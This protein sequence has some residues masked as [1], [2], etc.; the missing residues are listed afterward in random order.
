M[1][2]LLAWLALAVAR[3]APG[4]ALDTISR[5]LYEEGLRLEEQHEYQKAAVRFRAVW[6]RDPSF[7]HALVDL[8]RVLDSD[9]DASGAVAAYGLAPWDADAVEARGRLLLRGGGAEEALGEFR[10]LRTLRPGWSAGLLLEAEAALAFDARLAATILLDYLG[11]PDVPIQAEGAVALGARIAMSL[12]AGGW[13]EE[14]TAVVEALLESGPDDE[15]RARLAALIHRRDVEAI[16]DV[17]SRSAD[18]PLQP[19]QVEA[20]EAAREALAEGEIER[21]S[22]LVEEVRLRTP[23]SAETW[24]VRASVDEARGDWSEAERSLAIAEALE[25]LSAVWPAR[26]GRLLHERFAGRYDAE[27]LAAVERALEYAAADEELWV[28]RAE[29]LLALGQ[30]QGAAASASVYLELAPA[31]R[32]AVLAQELIADATRER[33]VLPDLPRSPGRP[34][35]IDAGAWRAYQLARAYRRFGEDTDIDAALAELAS[36]RQLQPRWSDALNLEA[37]IRVRRQEI[38]RAI[39]LYEQSL[40]VTPDQVG[41]MEVLA[42][43]YG[44]VG[45]ASEAEDLLEH[46]AEEGSAASL[47]A[48]AQAAWEAGDPLAAR[49]LLERYFAR[50]ASGSEYDDALRLRS[51]IDGFMRGAALVGGSLALGAMGIPLLL[52]V[53][54]RTGARLEE[55]LERAPSVFRDVARVCSAIRHEVIKHNTTVLGAVADA[56]EAGDPEPAKWAAS[57]LFGPRGAVS[58]FRHYV[59]E[60][61]QLGRVNGVRLN[62][63]YQDPALG[64]L[65]AAME[66]LARLEPDLREGRELRLASQLR[67]IGLALNERGYNALGAVLRRVCLLPLE[68]SV[69]EGA[70]STVLAESRAQGVSLELRVPPGALNVRLYRS[71]LDDILINLLRN[72]LEV[73]LAAGEDA[74][75][76]VVELEEDPMTF[77]ELVCVRVCDRSPMR[78]TTAMIRGRY[79]GRGLGLAVDLISRAGGSVH[80]EPQAGWSKAVVVRLPRVERGEEDA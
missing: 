13:V 5:R 66:G 23:W 53:R 37:E 59:A 29:V 41:V 45:R 65:I 6:E 43:L 3:A 7:K 78:L 14:S 44:R 60:L 17:L 46:A 26:R 18:Q 55:L 19:G 36:A 70:W 76:V 2:W 58:R 30:T 22:S 38:P 48:L 28:D 42:S 20:L 1:T 57:R 49:G 9:G 12:R 16:A 73:T 62:L 39:Q 79:I 77:L 80:V 51:D 11:T 8:G 21:A 68:R 40:Q 67:D 63:R 4:D 69:F 27:A 25:P 15:G 71:D 47:F 34:E 75:G 56:L 33:L 35:G 10:K 31:G 52:R 32:R 50:A 61:E 74:V 54:R 64:P 72:S 24:G